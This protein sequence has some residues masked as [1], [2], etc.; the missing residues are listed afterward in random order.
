MSPVPVSPLEEEGG[1]GER[2]EAGRIQLETG[3]ELA[4]AVAT[5]CA[6]R[7]QWS[8]LDRLTSPSSRGG[9]V[10]GVVGLAGAVGAAREL[11]RQN[12]MHAWHRMRVARGEACVVWGEV[13]GWTV[14]HI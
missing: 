8:L 7:A 3:L 11:S 14:S 5:A 13:Q 6:H 2:T 12:A 1:A 10:G 4:T 9:P